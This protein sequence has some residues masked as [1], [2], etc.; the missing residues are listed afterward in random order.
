MKKNIILIVFIVLSN[1][2]LNAQGDECLTPPDNSVQRNANS[3][4]VYDPNGP[5]KT[6]RVNFH[7]LLKDDGTGNFNETSDNYS[8]RLYNGY[9]YA[10]DMVDWCNQ[11]W[12]IN[13]E[14][15]HMPI[16]HVPALPKKVQLQ[17]CGVFF[18]R[19]TNDY[20]TYNTEYNIPPFVENSGEVL[21]FFI[22]YAHRTNPSAG[23]VASGERISM[24]N[25]YRNY[26]T[27]V[28]VN[29][30]WVNQETKK[31]FNHELGHLFSLPHA[32]QN[33]CP[34]PYNNCD[35]GIAD[36]PTYSE[37]LS[38]GYLPCEWN[39]ILGSNNLMDYV[40]DKY[41]LSPMQ[42]ARMHACID[43]TKLYYRNCKYKTQ[44]LNIT[45]FTMN[46][47]YIA[48]QVT[49]PSASNIVVANNS[50]LFINAEEVTIVG[51]FEVQSSSILNIETV[52]SCD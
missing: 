32:I 1:N 21:N 22:I 12:N 38:L 27:S 6:I 45:N 11:H 47:A 44:S 5:I 3:N 43:G 40:A 13:I 25:A 50:A 33:C 2:L 49:I 31:T 18:H 26:K 14:L 23:G 48:K 28:D 42:I 8:N 37:L 15:R 7:Y 16:S 51:S 35:D 41:A 36:T 4:Y 29:N 20:Y 17:L 46:K 30:N 9:M 24:F 52:S 19:N 10:D 39:G 34:N